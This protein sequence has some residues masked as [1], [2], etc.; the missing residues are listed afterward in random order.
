VMPVVT[1]SRYSYRDF[2]ESISVFNTNL[3]ASHH[4]EVF[5]NTSWIL[6][7]NDEVLKHLLVA[8]ELLMLDS[9]LQPDVTTT[10]SLSII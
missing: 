9:F 4:G 8:P 3:N 1:R 5:M 6:N 2:C 7:L 10:V